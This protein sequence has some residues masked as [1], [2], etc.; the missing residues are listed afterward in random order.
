M[1]TYF[2]LIFLTQYVTFQFQKT[3][4]WYH[5]IWHLYL[6]VLKDPMITRKR[7][8]LQ[9]ILTMSPSVL[10][11]LT[12]RKVT[13]I[14]SLSASKFNVFI[15]LEILIIFI[16]TGVIHCHQAMLESLSPKLRETFQVRSII[17][18]YISFKL[19]VLLQAHNCCNCSGS[20][21]GRRETIQIHIPD[22]TR[23]C[24]YKHD[25]PNFLCV[26]HN[27]S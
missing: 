21:C 17:I 14:L 18:L 27:H 1:D 3:C 19:L 9:P 7:K 11:D 24:I 22:V 6:R 20:S 5:I 4:L 16:R 8:V 15:W 10:P 13:Q 26:N 12:R 2:M 23:Y 25:Y